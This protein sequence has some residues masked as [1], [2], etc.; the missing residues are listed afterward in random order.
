MIIYNVTVNV[1]DSIQD[2]WIA[3]MKK[4]HIQA[5]LDTGLFTGYRFTKVL[6]EEESGTTYSIQYE[7]ADLE[8]FKLYE[9]I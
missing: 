4:E 5:V 3:W 8:S 9:Q 2:E 1:D 7:A 6:V